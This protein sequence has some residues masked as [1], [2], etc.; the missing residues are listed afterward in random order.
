[1]ALQGEN[2]RYKDQIAYDTRVN[3]D[4]FIISFFRKV[5]SGENSATWYYFICFLG[6][7][8]F[9]IPHLTLVFFV[10]AVVSF[11]VFFDR[12]NIV[13]QL[14]M[15]LPIH[16]TSPDG[17]MSSALNKQRTSKNK[18]KFK[19]TGTTYMGVDT[20]SKEQVWFSDD[21]L[22]THVMLLGT[23]K[24]GKTV[25]ILLLM[26]QAMIKNSGFFY[27]DGKGDI[28]TL[29]Y[30]CQIMRRFG[31]EADLTI[32]SF[33]PYE[34]SEHGDL[35]KPTNSLNIMRT[36]TPTMISEVL[37][38]MLEGEED[39]WK[40]RTI[41][42][43]TALMPPMC[44]ARDLGI[45]ELSSA[46]IL[47]LTELR[48]LEE[49]CW[50]TCEGSTNPRLRQAGYAI[51][52]YLVGL[53]SYDRAKYD[54]KKPQDSTTK[55]QHGFVVMQLLRALNDLSYNYGHIFGKES[56]DLDIQDA[57]FNRRNVVV[58]LPALGRS[59]ST[60]SM[61]G[62]IIISAIKQMLSLALGSTVEGSIRLN[63]DARPTNARNVYGLFFDEVGYYMTLGIS[64][65]PAQVRAFNIYSVFAGQTF[66]NIK[67]ADVNE[68]DEIW[69]NTNI[70]LFGR[71]VGGAEDEDFKKIQGLAGEAWVYRAKN[72][73][74]ETGEFSTT[75]KKTNH[76]EAFKE[77]RIEL[78]DL[79]T[80]ENGQFLAIMAKRSS[81]NNK[82]G[83]IAMSF[84]QSMYPVPEKTT[85]YI[86][87]NEFIYLNK[88]LL[89]NITYEAREKM[90]KP[91]FDKGFH[92]YLNEMHQQRSDRLNA[93][94]LKDGKEEVIIDDKL[95]DLLIH[96]SH[97]YKQS[98]PILHISNKMM[99]VKNYYAR[100]LAYTNGIINSPKNLLKDGEDI[101]GSSDFL[102]P[103]YNTKQLVE[104]AMKA[105]V[106]VSAYQNG[107]LDL[108]MK[109]GD[110]TISP[111][112]GR[113]QL[114]YDE[115]M[116]IERLDVKEL[117]GKPLSRIDTKEA[118]DVA[119]A[120]M[121]SEIIS[122]HLSALE[123]LDKVKEPITKPIAKT[124]KMGD[125]INDLF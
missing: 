45:L 74:R 91:V 104:M 11:F 7:L 10:V 84:F 81:L 55:D 44:V 58:S 76:V 86:Y 49:F 110:N 16:A 68:A 102:M 61:L 41:S 116:S 114:P 87:I 47:K 40:G 3:T 100:E 109:D 6:L 53:P 105:T 31:R 113:M 89:R 48:A 79:A 115:Q 64:I 13:Q 78:S 56:S 72:M 94:R 54:Q 111:M 118:S 15:R 35:T 18:A 57:V 4:H 29:K 117:K 42:Y 20:E 119:M 46:K 27:V 75:Y 82:D 9:M 96:F 12:E 90:L 121:G 51:R 37:I 67:K 95:R 108:A 71:Y 99:Q 8:C 23:T 120:L 123:S 83:E 88:E 73:T 125:S 17:S 28:V 24:S 14:P 107:V 85:G 30:I 25:M 98:E 77:H 1:M 92:Q 38:S 5:K 106:A 70:K 33:L 122:Q 103:S 32:L 63:V 69:K 36:A 112:N 52:D 21:D 26:L 39:M 65:I 59:P 101:V 2:S 22:L 34:Q 19:A 124:I 60:L 80:Q 62:R 50:E 93:Q 43:I 66:S 97:L